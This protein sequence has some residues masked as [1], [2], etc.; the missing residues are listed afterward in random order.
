MIFM[1][2]TLNDNKKL[3]SVIIPAYNA[4]DY[5]KEC[6]E[7]VIN[8]TYTNLEI[9][10]INDGSTDGTLNIA[11][12]YGNRDNR[13]TIIN[14][15][16]CGVY[17]TR[18]NGIEI[19][20]GEYIVF[21]DADDFLTDNCIEKLY[22]SIISSKTDIVRCNFKHYKNNKYIDNEL[23][24]KCGVFSK[25]TYEESIYKY[26]YTSFDFNSVCMQIIKKEI[27]LLSLQKKYNL[28]YGEDLIFN[29]ALIDNSKSIMVIPDKLYI[30]RT[31][32]NSYS[33][34]KNYDVIYNRTKDVLAYCKI[35]NEYI[36]EWKIN[37]KKLF[38]RYLSNLMY[39]NIIYQ[40][41]NI[42]SKNDYCKI[43]NYLNSND[44]YIKIGTVKPK[45]LSSLKDN[46]MLH[47]EKKL[48]RKKHKILFFELNLINAL[49]K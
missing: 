41:M 42:S 7:S 28:K 43:I 23:K 30:Y 6:I 35:L 9:I 11:N 33:K 46:I 37:N 21:L 15:K 25:E 12:D 14:Q 36:D 45:T 29:C 40:L 34:I 38:K 19:A 32:M 5:L 24:V 2:N 16:N 13:I 8:Q 22:N 44:I 39:K 3:I 27:A 17:K 4:E 26:V 20:K 18:C 49:L 31:N 1:R 10:I 48:Y 47:F